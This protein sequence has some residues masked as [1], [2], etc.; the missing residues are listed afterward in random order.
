[1][2][3]VEPRGLQ[4]SVLDRVAELGGTVEVT[5]APGHGTEIGIAVPTTGRR[6]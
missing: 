3:L 1:L 4:R 2:D 6:S 5:S